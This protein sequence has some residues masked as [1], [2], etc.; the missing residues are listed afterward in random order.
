MRSYAFYI[1]GYYECAHSPLTDSFLTSQHTHAAIHTR[2][3]IPTSSTHTHT[4]WGAPQMYSNSHQFR[5]HPLRTICASCSRRFVVLRTK[6]KNTHTHTLH[7]D[8]KMPQLIYVTER[9]RHAPRSSRRAHDQPAVSQSAS[10][11]PEQEQ[12]PDCS[13]KRL[14]AQPS[15]E[16]RRSVP[17][18][19]H[20][21]A[22]ALAGC[23]VRVTR[24]ASP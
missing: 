2:T 1:S 20:A 12:E 14:S 10:G 19:K 23:Q 16:F 13:E 15:R 5:P 17:T 24:D 3:H 7:P 6:K 4:K 18:H 8:S 21:L 22:M 9:G 11:R